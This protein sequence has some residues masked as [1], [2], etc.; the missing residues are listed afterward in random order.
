MWGPHRG[1]R[2][3]PGRPELSAALSPRGSA[4]RGG[5][6]MGLR[7]DAERGSPESW[8]RPTKTRGDGRRGLAAGSRLRDAIMGGGGGLCPG[9]RPRFP[10]A[11]VPESS[12]ILPG[13][14]P[15]LT[16]E[17]APNA[18][19]AR[20][21]SSPKPTRDAPRSRPWIPWSWSLSRCAPRG[22]GQVPLE[23]A[24]VRSALPARRRAH[25]RGRT[26]PGAGSRAP[27]R[28]QSPSQRFA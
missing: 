22:T 10:S 11:R 15:R 9:A 6:T 28:S 4:G 26:R 25:R 14:R 1:A 23:S 17:P 20:P 5:D 12:R 8:T 19:G 16:P 2:V 7:P 21:R 13:A 18:L 3:H 24:R 27:I